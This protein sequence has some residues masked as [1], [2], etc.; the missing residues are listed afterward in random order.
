VRLE[1]A[2]GSHTESLSWLARDRDTQLP[3]MHLSFDA[4]GEQSYLLIDAGTTS[5]GY[6]SMEL[7]DA[8]G[9]IYRTWIDSPFELTTPGFEPARASIVVNRS[10]QRGQQMQADAIAQQPLLELEFRV[11]DVQLN[12]EGDHGWGEFGHGHACNVV[13]PDGTACA[14]TDGLY[15]PI[16]LPETIGAALDIQLGGLVLPPR[17]VIIRGL[18]AQKHFTTIIIEGRPGASDPWAPG[19]RLDFDP[20]AELQQ[21]GSLEDERPQI[22]EVLN[23]EGAPDSIGELRVRL[24]DDQK[25]NVPISWVSEVSLY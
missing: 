7:R 21:T 5:G 16:E 14:L 10:I 13:Q 12:F 2:N 3:D 6:D 15:T 4:P 19:G 9:V 11:Q 1:W 23:W 18:W 17:F 8:R 25:K 20:N 24:E 22:F